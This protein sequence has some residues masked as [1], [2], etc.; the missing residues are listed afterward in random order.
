M[1]RHAM[2]ACQCAFA[3]VF[4]LLALT[5]EQASNGRVRTDLADITPSTLLVLMLLLLPA[6]AIPLLLLWLAVLT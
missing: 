1:K 6:T 2:N 5:V 3:L 4:A